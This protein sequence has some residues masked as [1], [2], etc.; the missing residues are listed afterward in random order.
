MIPVGGADETDTQ[1][2]SDVA[3]ELGWALEED[4]GKYNY[5]KQKETRGR[6]M[7]QGPMIMAISKP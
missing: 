5:G 1:S 7:E 4:I 3:H 2:W 6:K